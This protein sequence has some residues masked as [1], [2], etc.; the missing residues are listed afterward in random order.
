LGEDEWLVAFHETALEGLDPHEL[1][2]RDGVECEEL[3]R[4]GRQISIQNQISHSELRNS[5]DRG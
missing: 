5:R 3:D 4:E 1:S 2:T